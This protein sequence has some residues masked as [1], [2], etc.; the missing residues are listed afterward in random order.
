MA[1]CLKT[2]SECPT[3]SKAGELC[4]KSPAFGP[5]DFNGLAAS[6]WCEFC[7]SVA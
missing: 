3:F 7:F 6:T 4:E 2:L 1:Y 5:S